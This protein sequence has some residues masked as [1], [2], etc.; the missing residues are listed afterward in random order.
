MSARRQHWN[1]V[2][3]TKRANEVSWFQ[4]TA[5]ISL[6][7][8]LEES[9]R[10]AV[11]DIGGGASILVDQLLAAGFGDVS[12]LDISERPLAACKVRLGARAR[13]VHWI[14]GDVLQWT[15]PRVYDVW[16]DRA[17]FHFLTDV[18]DRSTYRSAVT[19]GLRRG[20][21][22]VLATFAQDGPEQCS[23]LP[24]QRWSA[25][26]LAAE[27]GPD[28]RLIESLRENHRTPGGVVQP[29]TWARFERV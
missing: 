4:A 19:K 11:I 17:V 23:G 26:G 1:E 16:H 3:A 7:L 6:E 5:D 22:F 29:F 12:V 9:P 8:M 20:G 28:F 10:A 24:V 18:R 15:P 25:G 21:S 14:V 13:D 27:L 2:Y